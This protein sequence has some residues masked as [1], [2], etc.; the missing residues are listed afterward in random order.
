MSPRGLRSPRERLSTGIL[1][2]LGDRLE[3]SSPPRERERDLRGE[4][5]RAKFV[6]HQLRVTASER[7]ERAGPPTR[8]SVV[9]HGRTR[10]TIK[11][12]KVAISS[13]RRRKVSWF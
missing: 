13:R 11:M 12:A 7:V 10:L 6:R 9:C 4:V 3:E 2:R 8:A 1:T 5:T